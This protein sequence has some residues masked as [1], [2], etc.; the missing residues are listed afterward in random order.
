MSLDDPDGDR[1]HQLEVKV[2]VL[3]EELRIRMS[4]AAFEALRARL[5]LADD[6]PPPD[7]LG[8]D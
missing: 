4:P 8:T 2:R 1:L 6:P 5:G 7:G 3:L